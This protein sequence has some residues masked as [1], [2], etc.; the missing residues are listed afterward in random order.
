M[1]VG[2][3]GCVQSSYRILQTLLNQKVEGI[4]VVA[5]ITKSE[6]SVNSDFV[7]LA[8]LCR[9]HDI[10]FHYEQSRE[11]LDSLEFLRRYQPDVI[12]CFGWSYLLDKEM[13]NLAPLGAIGF[14]PAPLPLARGRHPIIWA[15]ALG[16]EQTA[17]TFFRMDEGADSGPIIIQ[18]PVTIVAE[19]N[20]ATLYEKI[21]DTASLQIIDVSQQLATGKATF[22][23]QDHSKATYW[24]KRSRKDGLID[25]RMHAEDIHNLI[26]ALTYP[27][28]GAE[29]LYGESPISVWRSKLS[30]KLFP[31]YIEPGRILV[32][33][34]E[35][36][37]IKCGGDSAIWLYDIQL[38]FLPQNGECL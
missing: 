18:E 22:V 2:F 36:M 31:H 28:P 7:D 23:N 9:A 14:H 17:V 12:Y 26:R 24:R 15:L 4:E 35:K 10:P 27:Y 3:I 11:R 20:A 38:N 1:K 25:W 19:D 32:A 37:L 16:L 5:V 6:S 21:L 34:K 13:L 29:F 8:P 33:E 30:Q